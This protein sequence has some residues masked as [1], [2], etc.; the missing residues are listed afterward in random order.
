[1]SKTELFEIICETCGEYVEIEID[2]EKDTTVVSIQCPR[3][4]DYT[5]VD[6]NQSFDQEDVP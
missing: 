1:M 4:G 5:D 2:L 3:C 6:V